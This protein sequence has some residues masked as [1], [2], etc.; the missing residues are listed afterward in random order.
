M[1]VSKIDCTINNKYSDALLSDTVQWNTEKKRVWSPWTGRRETR[2]VCGLGV[3]NKVLL[4]DY[5]MDN[6]RCQLQCCGI[7]EINFG[8]LHDVTPHAEDFDYFDE[9]VAKY[10]EVAAG[11]AD[12]RIII[13]G[14]PTA[15]N[16]TESQYRLSFYKA[17]RKTL[18]KFGFVELQNEPYKNKNST[19]HIT[20]LAGQLPVLEN[21]PNI[22]PDE[23]AVA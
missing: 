16:A 21:I 6:A 18:R 11:H 5:H 13:V 7:T 12:R 15:L 19:N 9:F 17:L 10:I 20:V 23:E 4:K 14:V 8:P 2:T 3:N 1:L 22:I